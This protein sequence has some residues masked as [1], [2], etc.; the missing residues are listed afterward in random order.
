MWLLSEPTTELKQPGVLKDEGP[1][2]NPR[3]EILFPF[4]CRHTCVCILARLPECACMCVPGGGQKSASGVPLCFLRQA[5][6]SWSSSSRLEAA[7]P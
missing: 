2:V 4:T 1:M 7:C 5:S 6:A 3:S